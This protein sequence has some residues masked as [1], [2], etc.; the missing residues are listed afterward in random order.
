MCFVGSLICGA[1]LT[2]RQLWWAPAFFCRVYGGLS[3]RFGL[4]LGTGD[5]I[6]RWCL[7]RRCTFLVRPWCWCSADVGEVGIET[8]S[9]N[10]KKA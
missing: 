6:G 7:A 2:G 3:W 10:E 9:R 1:F 8:G 4:Y 5:H